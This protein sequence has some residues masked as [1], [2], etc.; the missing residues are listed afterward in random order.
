MSRPGYTLLGWIVWQV[1]RRVARRK[2]GQARVKLGVGAA[3][4]IA[5]AAGIAAMRARGGLHL[6]DTLSDRWGTKRYGRMRIWFEIDR[7]PASAA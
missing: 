6:V 2:V 1:G 7:S 5:L 4:A 3:V